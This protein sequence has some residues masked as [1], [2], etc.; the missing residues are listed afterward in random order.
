MWVLMHSGQAPA[1]DRVAQM[2]GPSADA[3]I[4]ELF[5]RP[6]EQGTSFGLCAL[7]NGEFVAERYGVRPS[8]DFEPAETLTSE[9]TLLSWSIAKS[10]TH[11]AV[12][13]LVADGLIDLE[14]PAP[15][16]EWAGTDRA[17]ITT[18]QLLEMRSGLRFVEDYV[19]DRSSHCIEMLFGG[20]DPSFAHY[21]ASQPLEHQPG[22]VFNYSS[23]TT[24]IVCRIIGD[25][26]TGSPGGDPAARADAVH[27]FLQE[28]LFEPTGMSSAIAK[29]D[30]AGDFVGSSFVYA[31]T[32]DFAR[33]GQL[34]LH[35][36][37]ALGGTGDRVLPAGWLDHAR[38]LTAHD[39][40]T[41]LGYGRHWWLWHAFPGSLACHGFEG[42]FVVV[43]P[44]RDLVLAHLGATPTPYNT[45]IQ[46]RLA[47][48]AER[49]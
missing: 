36:G 21:A 35:D 27:R 42:Q 10:I 3:L 34:Y 26:V 24:N 30:D 31:T 16:P 22:D 45:S 44:D 33:F 13:I 4:D 2:A 37:V 9:S 40:D 15:V 29:F 23:G 49:L 20:T 8:N 17:S 28:R 12:G 39:D 7:R 11:A 48:L 14:A 46:M 19:D 41:G 18:N 1:L 32:Q 25:L 43:F 38:S 6:A 5:A 47:R